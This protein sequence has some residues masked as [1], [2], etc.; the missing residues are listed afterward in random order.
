MAGSVFDSQIYGDLFTS[1]DVGRLF[2]DTA[3]ARAML[4]VE[5]ALARA[6]GAAGVIPQD[7]AAAIGRA[8]MEVAL[9]PGTLRKPTGQNGVPV[10]GLI[11]AF[12]AEMNAPEHA[13]YVHWGA[14]SQDIMDSALMLRLRQALALIEDDLKLALSSLAKLAETHAEL[15]MPARTYGQHATPTSFG[16][17][18][19]AWGAPLLAL[20]GE[21]E[22]LRRDCL[23]ISLSGAAGTSGALG[24]KAAEVRAEM[25]KALGLNDPER[26]W[27]SD[28][29]A[30]LRLMDWMVRVNLALGKLG[31][32]CIALVQTGIGEIALG[33]AGASSTMPQKQNPVAPSVLVAL[34]RQGSGLLS[35]LHG[36]ALQQHQRDGAAW[37]SEWLCL[38]QIVLGCASAARSGRDLCAG[39]TPQASAMA[40]ALARGLDMIHAEALSFALAHYMPRPEAQALVKTLCRE[41][42]D[43]GQPLRDL[44]ARDQPQ[45]DVAALFDPAMQL[46]AAPAEARRF[47]RKAAELP[48]D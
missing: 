23:L 45:L 14:T 20:V 6:Q 44:V 35:I 41:A 9:D 25:A 36:S 17:V 28:R 38:P 30:L 21:L 10:P 7:S 13:Q 48:A 39:I 47:A 16:A 26:S 29:T 43:T 37:F 31:E 1:G 27:H 18:V 19:A 24:P 8:V 34:A 4:L 5:G 15:P 33:G 11:A 3:E 32:D 2:T 46:G 42:Q 12:R 22:T 40:A